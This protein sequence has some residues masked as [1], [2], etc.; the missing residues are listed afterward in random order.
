[1]NV[2]C[3]QARSHGHDNGC[4]IVPC[5]VMR[6]DD[7]LHQYQA[8]CRYIG[9]RLYIK[10]FSDTARSVSGY[11]LS[12]RCSFPERDSIFLFK[13]LHLDIQPL[14]RVE[15]VLEFMR[16]QVLTVTSVFWYVAPCDLA[17]VCRR[18]RGAYGLHHQGDSV[19][20][21]MTTV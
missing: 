10:L 2:L 1:M 8:S 16:I 9:P 4:R 19:T 12:V 11:G 13:I 5:V 7:S 14:V 6:C 15:W 3:V 18:F 20:S 17:E 21:Q